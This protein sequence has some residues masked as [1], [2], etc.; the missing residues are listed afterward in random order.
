M[1]RTLTPTD[2]HAIMNALVKQATG[3]DNVT[4]FDASSF[5]SAGETVLAT[6]LENVLNSLNIVLGRT[7]VAARPYTGKLNRM[8]AIDTGVY[9]NR[10]RKISF[11][12]KYAVADGRHNTNLFTNLA[13]EFTN[14]QNTTAL[15]AAQ[16]TKSMWE[17]H[18]P[19]PLEMNFGGSTVWQDCI[20]TYEDQLQT[21]FRSVEDF[22]RF[23]AGYL[24]EH[25]NDIESQKEAFNRMM[26]LNKIASTY[27]YDSI[28]ATQGQVINLTA[29]FNARFGTSYTSAQLRSTYL[30]EFLAFFVATFK[31]ESKFMTERSAYRHLN[32]AKT[33]DGEDYAILRH[34]PYNRQRVYL[35][36]PLFTEAE[37]LVLPE[38]FRPNYLDL[39]TQYEEVNYWQ[40]ISS[41]AEIDVTPAVIDLTTGEQTAA[42]D[43]VQ[44]EYVVGAIMDEDALM[45]NYQLDAARTTPI[46]ARKGY[47]N[48]WLSIAK[49]GIDDGSE[50]CVIFIMADPEEEPGGEG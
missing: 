42:D 18:Q 20:T 39:E 50:N 13:D 11:Y 6:G 1:A 3:V 17:Q 43:P 38:I 28:S 7:L 48:T 34:T 31:N 23:V 25:G 26:L 44:L 14:G 19:M 5:I 37:A 24:T 32:F 16:S 40:G 45:T 27:Y 29:A 9:S 47:Y 21:A 15:G 8:Q 22:T 41:R 12:S 49:N 10:M 35:Y 36:A 4:S 30:K 2:G 33:V 46:E